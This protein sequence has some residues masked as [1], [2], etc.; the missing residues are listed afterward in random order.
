MKLSIKKVI[1]KIH[2]YLALLFMIP[3]IILGVTGAIL[4]FE[5]E[6]EAIFDK[7]AV[8]YDENKSFISVDEAINA[9]K[10][11]YPNH[12]VTFIIVPNIDTNYIKYR[13]FMNDPT[14]KGRKGRK[15][16]MM[17]PYTGEE[18]GAGERTFI[19]EFFSVTLGIHRRLLISGWGKYVM[20][21]STIG[22]FILALSGIVISLP[23]R[24]IFSKKSLKSMFTMKWNRKQPM[25]NNYYLHKIAGM[26]L[27]LVIL[28]IAFTGFSFTFGRE[29]IFP[30]IAK[31]TF[32]KPAPKPI[33][34]AV[35]D[36]KAPMSDII[37]NVEKR[38]GDDQIRYIRMPRKADNVISF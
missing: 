16:M 3:L 26:Y 17:N 25:V 34:V 36:T 1:T 11:D 18:L 29:Y 23:K 38:Y 8:V 32:S 37:E 2:T 31:I 15:R 5:D 35:L 20:A 22:L 12:Q 21:V 7:N 19:Q 24:N 6:I 33:K 4:T 28:V 9:A 13:L 27:S 30:A 14:K 10:K